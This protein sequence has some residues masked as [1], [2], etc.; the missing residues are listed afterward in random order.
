MELYTCNVQYIIKTIYRKKSAVLHLFASVIYHV[1]LYFSWSCLTCSDFRCYQFSP[2]HP[3]SWWFTTVFGWSYLC[4]SGVNWHR[5]DV[6]QFGI[7]LYAKLW[8][9]VARFLCLRMGLDSSTCVVHIA[10]SV[11]RWL[12]F[13]GH[14]SGCLSDDKCRHRGWFSSRGPSDHTNMWWGTGHIHNDQWG[15][16]CAKCGD[17]WCQW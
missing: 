11:I 15:D 17:K 6:V 16:K 10:K 1:G 13:V 12:P 14:V 9:L 3:S 4:P 8:N 2:S 5:G 7:L